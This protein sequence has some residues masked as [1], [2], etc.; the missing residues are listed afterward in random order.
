MVAL[1]AEAAA[2]VAE[3]RARRLLHHAAELPREL[4]VAVAARQAEPLDVED[5]AANRRP[6]QARHHA[7]RGAPPQPIAR[8]GRRPEVRFEV[9]DPDGVGL[10]PAARHLAGRLAT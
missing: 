9:L 1:A 6:G 4:Q 5:L 3:R 10:A 8:V 7:R 2:Q